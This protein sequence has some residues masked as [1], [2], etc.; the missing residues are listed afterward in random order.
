MVTLLGG[1][2]KKARDL[3][4]KVISISGR[5][6]YIYD[7]DGINTDEKIDFLVQIRTDNQTTLEDYAKKF[8]CQFFKNEKPW[9][10]KGDI[11]IPC[12][13]QNEI[14]LEDAKK[15]KENGVK[16]IIE[17]ANMPTTPEAMAFF[18]EN[19]I[20]LAPA[21]AANAGGVAVSALEMAQNSMR[22]SWSSEE[23]DQK[24]HQ[25]MISIH[26]ACKEASAKYN[27]GYD[28]VAGANIAGFEK[29]VSAMI[30]QGI[31]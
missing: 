11:A 17:G 26:Q 28:L 29:V 31:Y 8:N 18:K 14:Q 12:A 15:L 4:A 7:P 10:L 30:S 25:I 9:G 20:I 1:V 27:L 16:Y 13:T 2:C 21:K 24:L 22:Y 3:G 6:G 19:N 23:V 5:S